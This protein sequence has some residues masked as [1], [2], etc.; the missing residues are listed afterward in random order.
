MGDWTIH[1]EGTGQHH[2]G[3]PEDADNMADKFVADLLNAGQKV[4]AA[5]ITSGGRLD[6]AVRRWD[7]KQE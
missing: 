3:K 1:I 6:L 4:K 5:S 7:T 2:N